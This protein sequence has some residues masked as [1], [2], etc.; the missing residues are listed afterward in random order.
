M[1]LRVLRYFLAVAREESISRAAEALYVTQPNLS[2][3]MKNLEDELD[4]RLFERGSRKI[5]LTEAG[6]LL[7]KRAEEILE[8]YDRA[9]SELKAPQGDMSGEVRIGGGESKAFSLIA[10]AICAVQRKYPLVRFDVFSGDSEAVSDRLDNGLIDFGVFIEPTD[11]TRY[12]SLRLPVTDRWGV[13]MRKDHPL[14]QS[15]SVTA[16]DLK[17]QPLIR[18]RHSMGES[19]ITQW[20]GG[21]GN[22][23]ATYNLLYNASLMVESGVG[24]ALGLDGL[25]NTDGSNLCFKPLEP[26]LT[27]HLDI[28][29][30]KYGIFS[31]AAEKFLA[32]LKE[33][34]V[35]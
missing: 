33:L 29:W 13:L 19:M 18:S 5:V 23:A 20:L 26:E 30:K 35:K 28:A 1:E 16:K 2:R 31:P 14:A 22:I 27:S 25:I 11:L 17:G 21:D 8:L 4:K 7:K 34:I 12:D 32:E 9:E 24:L 10:R 15:A 6:K 3:Q